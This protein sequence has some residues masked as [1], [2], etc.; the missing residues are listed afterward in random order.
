MGF[1]RPRLVLLSACTSLTSAYLQSSAISRVWDQIGIWHYAAASM[2]K[3]RFEF[4]K[5]STYFPQFPLPLCVISKS[6][7]RSFLRASIL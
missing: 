3:S 4:R 1:P 7:I 5:V 2:N 6:P